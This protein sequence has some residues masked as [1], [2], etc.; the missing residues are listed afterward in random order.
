MKPQTTPEI[1]AARNLA[2]SDKSY[3]MNGLFFF[4][5]KG[6]TLTIIASDGEEWDHVSVSL[7]HRCPT[8]DEMCFIKDMFFEEEEVV[9]QLH[10]ARSEHI[11]A[12]PNCLHLWRPQGAEMPTPPTILVGPHR[13]PHGSLRKS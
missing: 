1:E 11:N 3:G 10:P 13:E 6:S 2:H 9:M 12:H 8:W 5:Q 7:G 4:K